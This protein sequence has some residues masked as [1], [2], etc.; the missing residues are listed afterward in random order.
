MPLVGGFSRGS[1]VSPAPSFRCRSIFTSITLIGS[2]NLAVKSRQNLLTSLIFTELP[3]NK[4]IWLNRTYDLVCDYRAG[5][6]HLAGFLGDIPFPP[7]LHSGAALY[8]STRFDFISFQDLDLE[9]RPNHSTP[10]RNKVAMDENRLA[11]IGTGCSTRGVD[12]SFQ[13]AIKMGEVI[14]DG[15]GATTE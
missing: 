5:R 15:D 3:M 1:P 10:L 2:Q 12:T 6:C 4:V 9:S 7:P 11:L 14:W 13:P 8:S